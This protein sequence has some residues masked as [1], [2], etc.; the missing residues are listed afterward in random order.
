MELRYSFYIWVGPS[1]A[2]A[3]A[4]GDSGMVLP[5]C[6]WGLTGSGGHQAGL[7]GLTAV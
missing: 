2:P 1:G 3:A 6:D 7:G 4:I 5:Y